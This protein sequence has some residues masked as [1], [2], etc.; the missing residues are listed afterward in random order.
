MFSFSKSLLALIFYFTGQYCLG[1]TQY[2]GTYSH[3]PQG[4]SRAMA[5]GGAYTGLSDDATGIIYNPAG[6]AQGTWTFDAGSTANTTLNREADVNNDGSADGVIFHFDFSAL[7]LRWGSLAF[8]YGQSSP[9]STQI[10]SDSSLFNR[11][12]IELKNTDYTLSYKM[13]DSLSI[14]LTQHNTVLSESYIANSSTNQNAEAK[15]QYSTYGI[16]YRVEKKMGFGFSF[17]PSV[18]IDVSNS[19]NS[20]TSGN[21][22][23]TISWFKGV[24][25]PTRYTFGGFFKSSEDLLYIA[26]LDFIKPLENSVLVENPFTQT[27]SSNQEVKPQTIQIPHGGIEYTV[28]SKPKRTF[29]WRVGSYREPARVVGGKDRFHFTMGVELRLGALVVSASMDETSGFS[30]SSQSVNFILGGT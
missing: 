11:A 18:K 28:F 4:S 21:S 10:Y 17:T 30:N 23:Y 15:S 22:T 24:A 2:Y 7:A 8:G 13:T 26:D 12:G 19:Y 3:A 20:I 16:S 25:L 27:S 14:G 6:L 29:I 9:Y 5:L 1:Q